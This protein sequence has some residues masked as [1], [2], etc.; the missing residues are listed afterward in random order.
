MIPLLP[1]WPVLFRGVRTFGRVI[2]FTRN[3]C[4][5]LGSVGTYPE[6]WCTPCGRN[7]GGGDLTFFFP[8]WSR[9]FVTIQ[10]QSGDWL[11]SVEFLDTFGKLIHRV[12][13]TPESDSEAFRWWV[14][15]N[16]AANPVAELSPYTR[17]PSCVEGPDAFCGKD[18]SFL[19]EN[20]FRALLR[21]LVETEI[22]VQILVG[23][24]GLV[25]GA[26]MAPNC[27]RDDGGW[28]YLGDDD[29][30]LQLRIGR[31]SQI[32]FRWSSSSLDWVLKAYEPEGRLVC[33][34]SGRDVEE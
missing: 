9:A 8:Y 31:P 18:A 3:S 22:S 7:G 10:E 28:I 2:S 16:H 5:M 1:R 24:D 29:C 27:L 33:T 30:G 20:D 17:F 15:L 26:R 14:E 11:Y 21:R 34:L 32:S 25:Q 12:C 13:L 4:A 19:S 6:V 23:N